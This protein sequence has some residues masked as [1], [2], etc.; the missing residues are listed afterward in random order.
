MQSVADVVK[1]SQP[2]LFWCTRSLPKSK[3]EAIYTLF[4]FCRHLD[5]IVCSA[6]PIAEKQELLKQWREELDNIYDKKVPV[7]NIGRKIYKNCMRFN[8]SKDLWLKILDGV[9]L[10]V[11]SPLKAPSRADFEKYCRCGSC[12]FLF[13][14]ADYKWSPIGGKSRVG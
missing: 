7:S 13:N 10:N 8:L 5:G 14:V 2:I 12:T 1:K 3:R 6:M 11:P 9:S 4:A